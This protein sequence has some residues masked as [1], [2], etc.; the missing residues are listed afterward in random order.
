M[1]FNVTILGCSSALPTSKRNPTAQVLNVFE[2]FFLIDCGEGTQIQLRKYGA[3]LAKI[4]NIF[5]SHLHGD[6]Y[7]GIFGL[8][9]SFALIGRKSDLHIYSDP[10]LEKIVNYILNTQNEKLNFKIIFHSLD[11]KN[12]AQIYED[13]HITVSSF[14][15]KH[16]INTCGFLFEE[17]EKQK[18]ILK[19]AIDK[20][21]LSLKD[22]IRIKEGEDFIA[23]DGK[24]ISNSELTILNTKERS[25]AYCSDTQFQEKNA[26]YFQNVD[27]LFHEATFADNQEKRAK[28]TYHST[29]KQAA[30]TAKLANAQKLV[31]GHFSARYKDSTI[32]LNEAKTIFE[33]T[34]VAEDGLKIQL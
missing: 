4:D 6:H 31:I 14:P 9:S 33:N 1:T 29:A 11:F 25:Y 2:R 17:K 18:N 27:V 10:E 15:L 7:F 30:T 20:Y 19:S 3:K 28:E 5:I 34:I 16:R 12:K 13:K 21:N 22:I 32:L 8:I 23:E 26:E 24:L